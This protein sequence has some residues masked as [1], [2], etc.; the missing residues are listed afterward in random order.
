M[1]STFTPLKTST[2]LVVTLNVPTTPPIVNCAVDSVD[3]SLELVILIISLSPLLIVEFTFVKAAL[4]T[5]YSPPEIL[6]LAAELMPAIVISF[7]Y[8]AVLSSVLFALVKLKLAGTV[9]VTGSVCS[10]GFSVGLESLPP[11]LVTEIPIRL[12]NT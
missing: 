6:I 10:S 9:S 4:L 11:Q 7:E 12:A 5:E 8:I 3:A 1:I 2:A